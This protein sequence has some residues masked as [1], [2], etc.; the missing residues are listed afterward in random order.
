MVPLAAAA[1]AAGHEVTFAASS[2]FAG[3]L[4]GHVVPGVPEGM[5]LADAERE[6]AAEVTDRSDPFAWPTALF[7]TV[8]PRRVV[9]SL[10]EIWAQDPA[11]VVEA[12]VTRFGR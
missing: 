7:G 5:T 3:R 4:P 10:L 12:L 6:A 8:M 1:V 2:R 9:P 11:E